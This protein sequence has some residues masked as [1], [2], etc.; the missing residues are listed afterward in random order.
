MGKYNKLVRDLIPRIIKSNGEYPIVR[1]LG[2]D[3]YRYELERKLF[4]EY[5]E[6]IDSCTSDERIEEL[7]DMY[8]VIKSLAELE[9]KSIEDVINVADKKREKRGGFSKRIYLDKVIQCNGIKIHS[10]NL[11]DLPFKLIND[12]SK[13]IEMRLYDNKRRLINNGDIIEFNNDH[14]DT[15][16]STEVIDLHI[17]SNFEDLYNAFD[18]ISLGYSEDD[19][20][21]PY[22]M[23]QYYSE[24]KIKKYGVVGIEIRKL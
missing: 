9:G 17:Y 18:K 16:I 7:A 10:M 23:E 15:I 4:E 22:D 8:E 13:T 19:I 2:A 14:S 21:N 20:A 12:G 1:V 6:V 3:Q 24:E 5:N 11:Q